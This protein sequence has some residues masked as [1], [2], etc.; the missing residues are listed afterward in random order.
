MALINFKYFDKVVKETD[1]AERGFAERAIGFQQDML[2]F[3][4]LLQKFIN[5]LSSTEAILY[6][7]IFTFLSKILVVSVR[8]SYK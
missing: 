1:L 3:V 2:P 8:S 4:A 7:T 5:D 6:G